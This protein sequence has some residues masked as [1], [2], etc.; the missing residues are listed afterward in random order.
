MKRG[1]LIILCCLSILLACS[2]DA[3]AVPELPVFVQQSDDICI[4]TVK[5]VRT[6]GQTSVMIGHS[7]GLPVMAQT[8][9]EIAT[10]AVEDVLKGSLSQAS[11]MVTFTKNAYTSFNRTSFTQLTLGERA[12]FFLVATPDKSVLSLTQPASD[13]YSRIL[14]GATNF[15]GHSTSPLRTTLLAL[16][17]ALAD[18]T[19]AIRLSCL[20]RIASAGFLLNVKPEKDVDRFGV[21]IRQSLGEPLPGGVVP[22]LSLEQ[23]IKTQ[24]VPAV[25]RLTKDADPD[26]SEQAFIA[27]GYLQ[28][29]DVVPDL[30]RVADK[31]GYAAFAIGS[32]RNVD[33][34]RPIIGALASKNDVVREKAA[35]ALRNFA[36][37]LAVPSLLE[38]LDD[39]DP[40][41]QY[42]IVTALFEATN[43]PHYPGTVLFHE[44]AGEYV[45][46]W[47]KWAA[48]HQ[49]RIKALR[50]QFKADAPAMSAR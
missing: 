50:A 30:V 17:Q 9:N 23:F 6:L 36:D 35:Y 7:D 19:K 21:K 25:I 11:V 45:A 29:A 44:K 20:G 2:K 37:P 49:A 12:V 18:N 22:A 34:V 47:K 28:D 43:T 31:N 27:S 32:Y 33:A 3:H 1:V 5:D 39:P 46:F 13:G 16:T 26:V 14:I 38:H 8:E 41:A 10:V 15:T 24:I 48:G 40:D 4:G 42:Y